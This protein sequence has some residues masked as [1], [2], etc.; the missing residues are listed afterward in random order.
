M[1]TKNAPFRG[2]RKKAGKTVRLAKKSYKA[3]AGKTNTTVVNHGKVMSKKKVQQLER[4]VRNERQNLGKDMGEME[5]QDL[6]IIESDPRLAKHA[7][8][9][10]ENILAA[11]AS[12][13][14]TTL[15]A[16]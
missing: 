7:F 2:A 6:P 14:G 8:V 9:V 16:P 1:G 13:P 3:R 15:G 11:A 10:P 12:G 4:A 5:M